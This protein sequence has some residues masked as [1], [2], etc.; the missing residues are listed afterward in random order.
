MYNPNDAIYLRVVLDS[1]RYEIAKHY[2]PDQHAFRKYGSTESALAKIHDSITHLL[3]IPEVDA[4]RMACLDLL[5]AFDR[6]LH[7]KLLNRLFTCGVFR[8]FLLWFNVFY[9]DVRNV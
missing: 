8:G 5:K 3:D 1:V 4:V 9:L 2:C 7:S 6:V